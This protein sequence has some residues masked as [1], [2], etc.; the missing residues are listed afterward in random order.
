MASSEVFPSLGDVLFD[1]HVGVTEAHQAN[2]VTLTSS[3]RELLA[4]I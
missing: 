2:L 1:R 3:D 4:A